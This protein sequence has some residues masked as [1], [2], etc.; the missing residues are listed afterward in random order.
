MQLVE[1]QA[2]ARS[3]ISSSLG[4]MDMRTSAQLV[5]KGMSLVPGA[6]M[7]SS[8]EKLL[9]S[10][11]AEEVVQATTEGERSL[12]DWTADDVDGSVE[13]TEHVL[14]QLVELQ[15]LNKKRTPQELLARPPPKFVHD[16]AVLV[17]QATGFLPAL[18]DSWPDPRE[19]KLELLQHISDAVASALG[20]GHIEFEPENVLKGKEVEK[21]LRLLQLLGVA[22]AREKNQPGAGAGGT[23]TAKN[24]R[25]GGELTKASDMPGVLNAM[26]KCMEKAAHIL[27][28]QKVTEVSG[29]ASPTRELENN[30]R[31]LKER[32]ED[33]LQVRMK[34]EQRLSDLQRQLQ[35]E[36][37]VLAERHVQLD[38]TR[39]AASE[40][41]NKK[42]ELRRQV[43][44]LRQGLLQRAGQRAAESGNTEVKRLKKELEEVAEIQQARVKAKT[45]LASAVKKL[46]QETLEADTQ[47][48]TLELEMQRMKLRLAE[49]LDGADKLHETEEIVM[50]QAEKQKLDVKLANLEEKR[51]AVSE[52]DDL[53]RK[54]ET[55][56][57]EASREESKRNDEI[58]MQLQVIIEERDALRDGMDQLWQEKTRV[59]EELE[60]VEIGYGHLSERLQEKEE[61][62]RELEEKLQQYENLA[63]MLLENSEKIHQSPVPPPLEPLS[64]S[65]IE[66]PVVAE[67]KVPTPQAIQPQQNAQDNPTHN[68]Q[69]GKHGENVDDGTSSHYSDETFEELDEES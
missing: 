65:K 30:F 31:A 35:S 29:R 5:L 69:A 32:L 25:K 26:G 6:T 9:R 41:G 1:Q 57:V 63:S 22:A 51:R 7:D 2:Q 20:I 62:A 16:V 10:L 59:E 11:S 21:T 37:T 23:K 13:R 49:G 34:Q 36:K 66:V 15:H 54:H 58:Q 56:A 33:E 27:D 48:E 4:A 18:S 55:E 28:E 60:N 14:S 53:A 38:D 61:E 44:M 24:G 12:H 64:P 67:S 45:D 68:G 8:D 46:A 43:D 19:E 39:K 47:R 42:V 40:A 17:R 3:N 50:L 52:A